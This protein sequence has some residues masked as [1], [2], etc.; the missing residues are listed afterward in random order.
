[1]GEEAP[2]E[3]LKKGLVDEVKVVASG[4]GEQGA[5]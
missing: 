4:Y 2:L 1:L 5:A 3:K